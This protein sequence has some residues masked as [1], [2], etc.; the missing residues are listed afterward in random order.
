M[1]EVAADEAAAAGDDDV[2]GLEGILRHD[3]PLLVTF[4]YINV[5]SIILTLME[6]ASDVHRICLHQI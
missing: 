3:S 6:Y 2:F 1:D 5:A 4:I